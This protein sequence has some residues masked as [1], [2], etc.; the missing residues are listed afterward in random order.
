MGRYPNRASMGVTPSVELTWSL[1]TADATVSHRLQSPCCAFAMRRRYC[2]THW[3]FRS[4]SLSV[5][6]WKAVDRFCL[7]P[8]LLASARPKWEVKWGSRLEM[9]FDGRPNHRYTLSKYNW[10][11]P[12][13]VIVVVQ[14]RKTAA[15][16]HP[17]ST[18]VNTESCGPLGGSPVIRSRAICW[19]GSVSSGVGMRYSR[20]CVRWVM[21]LFCWH[22]AHPAT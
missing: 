8:I 10:A 19:K 4:E 16:E 11:T 22:V 15:R 13:P 7:A 21:F 12:G 6:G 18:I 2:S 5:W 20:V 3:F 14:G 9:I 1:C 17:W